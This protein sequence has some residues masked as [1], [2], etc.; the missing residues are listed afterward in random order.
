M[1]KRFLKQQF[2][3]KDG[4]V[5]RVWLCVHSVSIIAVTDIEDL[6]KE[7]MKDFPW[8]IK[9][10]IAIEQSGMNNSFPKIMGIGFCVPIGE[11]VPASYRTAH[12]E[13]GYV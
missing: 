9:E 11:N 13:I 8:L 4:K 10:K 3:N 5:F 12:C 2:C 6:C 1:E 7:A